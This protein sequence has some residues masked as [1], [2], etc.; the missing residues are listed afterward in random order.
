MLHFHSLSVS[1]QVYIPA[2]EGHVPREMVQTLCAFLE[3]C[4]IARRN[5]I[6]SVSLQQLENALLR[7]HEHRTIFQ[8]CGVHVD[9]FS[10]P[11]QHSLIHY[12]SL[13]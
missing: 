11:Q 9:G 10:L 12:L 8:E 4:Y 5:V 13:I 7:F 2:I 3:F 6:D 1:I